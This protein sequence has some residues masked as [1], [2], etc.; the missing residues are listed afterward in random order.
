VRGTIAEITVRFA[1]DMIIVTRDAQG[2]IVSGSPSSP[3]EVVD[4]WTFSRNLKSSDPN[5]LLIAT[6]GAV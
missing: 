6:G 1:S 2:A 5:W 4:L 3:R